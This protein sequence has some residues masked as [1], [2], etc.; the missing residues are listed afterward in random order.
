M[1]M[2]RK[3]LYITESQEEALKRRSAETGVSEAELVRRALDTAL[4]SQPPSSW[5]PD[6]AAALSQLRRAWSNPQSGLDQPFDRS[7]LYEERMEQL[8]DRKT[9]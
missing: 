7:A 2:V 1:Y 6:N 9:D 4:Q 5:R 8:T 3:Q